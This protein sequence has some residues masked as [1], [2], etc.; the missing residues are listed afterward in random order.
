MKGKIMFYKDMPKQA[1]GKNDYCYSQTQEVFF[2]SIK[3]I[4]LY[5]YDNQLGLG[6]LELVHCE[7][8]NLSELS[9]DYWKD[10][11]A[12]DHDNYEVPDW[13]S[14][15]IDRINKMI[16]E[17]PSSGVCVPINVAVCL[18]ND[19]MQDYQDY[20]KSMEIKR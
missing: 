1:L 2:W 7:E 17:R 9:A 13:L 4:F 19:F 5:C 15:E 14:D 6:Q 11:L 10:D 8:L 18:T 16:K 3:E 20:K 12:F